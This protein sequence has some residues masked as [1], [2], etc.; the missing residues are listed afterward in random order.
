MINNFRVANLKA[1]RSSGLIELSPITVFF[2]TNSSGKTSLLQ[3]LLLLKQTAESN[4]RRL[5]LSTSGIVDLGVFSDL[6][7]NRSS[8]AD[9]VLALQWEL[10][11][12][13]QKAAFRD[14]YLGRAPM[15][16]EVR[17]RDINGKPKVTSFTYSIAD[18]N[19]GVKANDPAAKG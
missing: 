17:V 13:S 16:F 11:L 7:H 6:L 18:K 14:G 4:D 1:W 12:E 5:V 3:S 8:V 19:V 15:G 10:L 9:L 2:G